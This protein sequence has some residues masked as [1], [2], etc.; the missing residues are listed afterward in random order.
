MDKKLLK[1]I[2]LTVGE[3]EVNVSWSAEEMA[4]LALGDYILEAEFNTRDFTKTYQ[5][6]M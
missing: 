6:N 2:S 3:S 5:E 1:E 4:T